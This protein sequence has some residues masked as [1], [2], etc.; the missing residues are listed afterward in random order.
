MN[1]R[2]VVSMA[3]HDRERPQPQH[4][5]SHEYPDGRS[6]PSPGYRRPLDAIF[7]RFW[8][9]QLPELWTVRPTISEHPRM[10]LRSGLANG[11]K[12]LEIGVRNSG[13]NGTSDRSAVCRLV[14]SGSSHDPG[15]PLSA[16]SW[17][18]C[19]GSHR[20]RDSVLR[21]LDYWLRRMPARGFTSRVLQSGPAP[22]GSKSS[23]TV[24]VSRRSAPSPKAA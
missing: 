13:G 12:C 3:R 7:W 8:R 11:R 10:V 15:S 9:D 14:R 16:C 18:R 21:G 19:S 5:R 17:L 4:E 24:R 2:P 23:L 22:V 20:E 1:R 6:I